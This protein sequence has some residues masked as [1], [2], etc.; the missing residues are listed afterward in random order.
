MHS[1][2]VEKWFGHFE[3]LA[4]QKESKG[5]QIGG[6]ENSFSER[7]P[8]PP[9]HFWCS[10]SQLPARVTER[11]APRAVVLNLS[12]AVENHCSRGSQPHALY[13]VPPGRKAL[14]A[15]PSWY[16][17]LCEIPTQLLD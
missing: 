6:K 12:N 7:T 3:K 13:E 2:T 1:R 10:R 14:R 5:I 11:H 9:P 8:E 4:P 16:S 15:V 17:A